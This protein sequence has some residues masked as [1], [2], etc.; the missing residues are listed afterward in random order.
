MGYTKERIEGILKS[1]WEFFRSG[2]T[3]D[4]GWRI[5]QLKKLKKAVLD[6][7]DMLQDALYKDLGKSS[8]VAYLCDIGPVIVEVNE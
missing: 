1:Q 8:F 6:N 5:E 3:L 4:I 7:K 2:E